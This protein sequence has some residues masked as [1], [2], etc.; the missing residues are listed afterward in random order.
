[1]SDAERTLRARVAAYALHAQRDSRD[2]TANARSAAWQRFVTAVDPDGTL[3]EPERI[4]RAE[5]LRRSHLLRAALASA[6]ARRTKT[7]ASRQT[8]HSGRMAMLPPVPDRRQQKPD[9]QES[10]RA[11]AKRKAD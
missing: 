6:K 1:M 9:R 11:R 3:P 5:S 7:N 4:R 8:R 10:S 2:L